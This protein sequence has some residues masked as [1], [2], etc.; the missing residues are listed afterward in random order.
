MKFKIMIVDDDTDLVQ[1]LTSALEA[2]GYEV[3]SA[4]EPVAGLRLSRQFH[5]DLIILDYHM[6]GTSGAHLFESFRRNQSTAKTPIL[7]MSGQASQEQIESE[8]A[9]DKHI[10]FLPKPAHINDLRDTIRGMLPTPK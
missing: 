4:P 2:T 3:Q 7:F 5:P 8:I 1:I 10:R 9:D 6:P